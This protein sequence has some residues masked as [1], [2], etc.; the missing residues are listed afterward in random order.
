MSSSPEPENMSSFGNKDLCSCTRRSW[1]EEIILGYPDGPKSNDN[2]P[3]KSSAEDRERGEGSVKM[4]GTDGHDV[5][6]SH[7]TPWDTCGWQI[8]K[9]AGGTLPQSL[10]KEHAPS[11]P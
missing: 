2:S 10:W 7:E 5:A 3:C 4:G 11:T 6:T 1:N 8:L 9:E